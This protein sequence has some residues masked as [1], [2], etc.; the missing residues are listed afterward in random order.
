MPHTWLHVFGVPTGMRAVPLVQPVRTARMGLVAARRNVA[1]V[2]ARAFIE[3]AERSEM[4]ETL[5]R[6][7]DHMA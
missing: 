1:S 6:L 3:V 5:E 4:A 2:M 7:P